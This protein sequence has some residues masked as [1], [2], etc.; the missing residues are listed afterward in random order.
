M[1]VKMSDTGLKELEEIWLQ[2]FNESTTIYLTYFFLFLLKS[3]TVFHV[4]Y[5]CDNEEK[6]SPWIA[7][8]RWISQYNIKYVLYVLQIRKLSIT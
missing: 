8:A 5:S 3:A 1:N 2:K 6:E 4:I 7:L